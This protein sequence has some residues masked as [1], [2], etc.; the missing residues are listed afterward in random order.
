MCNE[1]D[2]C[3]G[4]KGDLQGAKVREGTVSHRG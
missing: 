3:V 1:G 2:T 4:G